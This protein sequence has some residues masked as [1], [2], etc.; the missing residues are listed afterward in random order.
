MCGGSR[1]DASVRA[2]C[3]SAPSRNCALVGPSDSPLVSD[4]ERLCL[5]RSSSRLY[6]LNRPCARSRW[7]AN[8]SSPCPNDEASCPPLLPWPSSYPPAGAA[9]SARRTNVPDASKSSSRASRR[10]SSSRSTA[11]I[12]RSRAR[13]ASALDASVSRSRSCIEG[14]RWPV[15]RATCVSALRSACSASSHRASNQLGRMVSMLAAANA[16]T[17]SSSTSSLSLPSSPLPS[18]PS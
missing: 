16:S 10:V 2:R 8:D 17:S 4:R 6:P 5:R 12:C 3:A 9:R 1:T 7:C 15:E 13:A 14:L 11:R 18:S